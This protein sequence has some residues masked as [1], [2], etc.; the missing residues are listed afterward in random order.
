MS[1]LVAELRIAFGLLTR[2]PVEH[3][4]GWPSDGLARAAWAFPL[5]GASVGLAAA[6]VAALGAWIGLPPSLAALAA[7]AGMVA[8]TGALHE[9]GLADTADALG[10]PRDR[11]RALAIMRD[12]RIGTFGALALG[13]T[14]AARVGAL[15][16]LPSAAV[17]PAL[18]GACSLSR[19]AMVWLMI[20]LPA[21]RADGL[22]AS[23][24]RPNAGRGVAAGAIG[25]A[26]ALAAGG[27]ANTMAQLA[28]TVLLTWLLR[29]WF[30]QRLGGHTGD[31]LG[32][33]QQIVEA[34]LLILW[35]VIA[36]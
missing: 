3:G 23:A 17:L 30:R 5:V 31:T 15:A 33:T 26:A 35:V 32:A 14:T 6:I 24:G 29:A 20:A 12:S 9:D 27:L 18:V 13:L 7:V 19:L 16:A 22:A 11:A 2:I 10:T 4:A 34:A 1:G 36:G 25:V 28:L 21:A 8:L